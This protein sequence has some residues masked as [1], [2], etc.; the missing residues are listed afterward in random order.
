MLICRTKGFRTG[1]SL[2]VNSAIDGVSLRSMSAYT[3]K[4][5]CVKFLTSLLAYKIVYYV[6]VEYKV[7]N[8]EKI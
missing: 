2:S 8:E 6:K 5:K 1:S 7:I 3:Y 4:T